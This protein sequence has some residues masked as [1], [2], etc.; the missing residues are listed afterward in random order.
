MGYNYE[1]VAAGDDILHGRQQNAVMPWSAT[2]RFQGHMDRV[3]LL[4]A[5]R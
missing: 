3:R 1:T 4:Y 5:E 2:L